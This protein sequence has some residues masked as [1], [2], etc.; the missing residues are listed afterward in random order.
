MIF[1]GDLHDPSGNGKKVFIKTFI[2]KYLGNM[3]IKS[4]NK[5]FFILKKGVGC[6][7]F[8]V[9]KGGEKVYNCFHRMIVTIGIHS[10]FIKS[11]GAA[12]LSDTHITINFKKQASRFRNCLIAALHLYLLRYS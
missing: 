7:M 12:L 9:G 3:L 8:V 10:V 11:F 6:C 2:R 1:K 4:L 5:S